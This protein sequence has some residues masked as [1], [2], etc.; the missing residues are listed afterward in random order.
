MRRQPESEAGVP[1]GESTGTPEPAP[2]EVVMKKRLSD[3]RGSGPRTPCGPASLAASA[4]ALRGGSGGAAGLP[5]SETRAPRHEER[6]GAPRRPVRRI[7]A[8]EATRADLIVVEGFSGV[9][10]PYRLA[11]SIAE[12]ADILGICKQSVRVLAS[13][14]RLTRCPGHR[15]WFT[16]HSIEA[17]LGGTIGVVRASLSLRAA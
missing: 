2:P 11:Y 6:R 14:G 7:A 8:R 12:A 17:L 15:G 3:R 16:R 13:C 9:R 10:Y 4:G 5:A 1:V